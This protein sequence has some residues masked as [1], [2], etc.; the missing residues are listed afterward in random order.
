MFDFH[1]LFTPN[2]QLMSTLGFDEYLD[3]TH[4]S[5]KISKNK[6]TLIETTNENDVQNGFIIYP[7]NGKL[8]YS[9]KL[10]RAV[11][12]K[13]A[14]IEIPFAP[15]LDM[16]PTG[17]ASFISSAT[18]ILK[19]CIKYNAHYI[20]TS[21]ARNEF[22]LKSALDLISFGVCLGLSPDQSKSAISN[23]P[24]MHTVKT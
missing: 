10:I 6:I 14:A 11:A 18:K 23:F 2:K 15:I 24:E 19:L 4:F 12:E 5:Q 17:K 21:R 8:I 3:T 9:A 13:K 20:I 1:I 22:E 7:F 16:D